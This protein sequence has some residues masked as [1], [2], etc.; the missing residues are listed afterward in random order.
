MCSFPW[1]QDAQGDVVEQAMLRSQ[2]HELG[3]VDAGLTN[4]TFALGAEY[5]GVLGIDSSALFFGG[6]SNIWG[7]K[8]MVN[9]R[10]HH[11]HH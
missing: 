1:L 11:S 5:R 7:V 9:M 8:H 3:F 10:K 6:V 2:H 4:C